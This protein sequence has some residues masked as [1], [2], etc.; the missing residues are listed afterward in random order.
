MNK[1]NLIRVI[2]FLLMII[3]VLLLTFQFAE[4]IDWNWWLVMIP[5]LVSDF[6]IFILI[7]KGDNE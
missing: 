4:I 5:V 3:Q 2:I 6:I 7:T 1:E